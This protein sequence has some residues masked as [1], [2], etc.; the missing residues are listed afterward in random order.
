MMVLVLLLLQ[1][2]FAFNSTGPSA[3]QIQKTFTWSDRILAPA[4]DSLSPDTNE[5][6]DRTKVPFALLGTISGDVQGNPLWGGV[7]PLID[8]GHVERIKALRDRGGDVIL[9]LSAQKGISLQYM[10]FCT[11]LS[12]DLL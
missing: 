6:S 11:V 8:P 4:L 12:R 5:W 3:V 10:S 2:T 7:E 1:T 9:S